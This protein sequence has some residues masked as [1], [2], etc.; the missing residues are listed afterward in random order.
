MT[1]QIDNIWLPFCGAFTGTPAA[2]LKETVLLKSTKDSQ[3][4]DGML[5]NCPAR[6]S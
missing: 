6:T 5:A 1:S 4:V 2:G 3:L